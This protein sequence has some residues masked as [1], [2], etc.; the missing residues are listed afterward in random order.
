MVTNRVE[1]YRLGHATTRQTLD[2]YSHVLP[3]MQEEATAKVAELF[4]AQPRFTP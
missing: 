1:V 3:G 4:G 2:T